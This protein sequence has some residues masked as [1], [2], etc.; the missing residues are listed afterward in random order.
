MLERM[1]RA[2]DA[3]GEHAN[4]VIV[5]YDPQNDKPADWRRYRLNHRLD[6]DNG[7]S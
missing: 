7:T 3:R 6:R 4:I 1:Q 2:L 5:G